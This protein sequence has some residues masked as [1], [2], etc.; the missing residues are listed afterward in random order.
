M[1]VPRRFAAPAATLLSFLLL[2][3]CAAQAAPTASPPVDS[4]SPADD[5]AARDAFNAAICPILADI[6]DLDPRLASMREAGARG[7]DMTVH[8]AEINALSD[9]LRVILE[10]LEAVPEWTEGA[11]VR[12]L[13]INGLHGI[14]ARLLHVGDDPSAHDAAA[15]LAEIPYLATEA[16]DIAFND[17]ALAGLTCDEES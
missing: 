14:R 6:V 16:M 9:E 12:Y 4:S 7:G 8:A 5:A 15:D 2:A 17:A 1:S 3:A 11:N 13:L 10:Q